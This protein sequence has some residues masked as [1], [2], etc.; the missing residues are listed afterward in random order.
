MIWYVD[1]A[2][3]TEIIGFIFMGNFHGHVDTLRISGDEKT[4]TA[5]ALALS[6]PKAPRNTG[7]FET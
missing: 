2:A 3:I 7:F 4:E 6:I 1:Y 5:D